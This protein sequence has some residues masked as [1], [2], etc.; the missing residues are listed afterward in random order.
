[1]GFRMIVADKFVWYHLGKTGGKTTRALIK[2]IEDE[3]KREFF[4]GKDHHRNKAQFEEKYLES[5]DGKVPVVGFRRLIDFMHSY[6]F[7]QFP[8]HRK[9]CDCIREGK[10]MLRNGKKIMPDK[11][12][13]NYVH[14]FY[15]EDDVEFLRLENIFEDFCRVFES[16]NFNKEKLLELSNVKV[17][18][19]KYD[20]LNLSESEI[21][22]VYNLNPIWK[23]LETKLYGGILLK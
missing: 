1:M 3:S 18:F 22:N 5:L 20:R 10:I 14:N 6:Y 7:Q 23:S 4:S 21:A 9:P 13:T 17:G 19:R 8:S 15:E 2:L 16:Y 11:I 12:L